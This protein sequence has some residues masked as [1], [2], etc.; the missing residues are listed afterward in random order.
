MNMSEFGVVKRAK[1]IMVS[2]VYRSGTTFLAAMLGAHSKLRASSSTIKFL[3]FCLGRYGD[4]SDMENCR[5]LVSDT[6]RRVQVRWGLNLDVETILHKA[7]AQKKVSY[8]L[9][10]DLMMRGMLIEVDDEDVRW[11]EKLAV[12]WEDIP[13][14]L[15]MFPNGKVV[16]I[17]RDPRDVTASYKGMTFEPG[18]TY[19]DAAFNCR[20]AMEVM[21]K[22]QRQYPD[23]LMVMKAEEIAH[24]PEAS[25]R[26]MCAFLGLDYE[27]SMIDA[28]QLH[29][30]GEDWASNT[31]FGEVYKKLPE[32]KPRWPDHLT[33]PEVIFVE[34]VSQPYLSRLGY[35][36][37]GYIPTVEDWQTIHEYISEPFLDDR[38]KRWLHQGKGSQGYR[39]DPYQHE[40]K[41]VF[42][43]RYADDG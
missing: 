42:P 12:Q 25:A 23:N 6:H 16:H 13:Y 5:R 37:S 15:D 30:E 1:P 41:I 31:S 29:T 7:E 24:C 18:C 19:L 17:Y 33:R 3:R 22:Y 27:D 38:F 14:F 4:V 28:G 20:A 2:G 34:M 21:E 35:E 9:L 26:E 10:Y 39:S 8:A 11:V 32:A 36:S 43:E 40:M